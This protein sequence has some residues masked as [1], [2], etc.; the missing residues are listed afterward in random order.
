M[1]DID[2]RTF[3]AECYAP[4]VGEAEVE[5]AGA[6]IRAVLGAA[7]GRSAVVSYSGA[8]LMPEDEVVFHT[9]VAEHAR[10]VDEICKAASIDVTRIVES[11]TVAGFPADERRP[12]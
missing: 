11:V 5:A 8:M 2:S 12:R 1:G 10:D 3:L 4:A 6:R 9:F 7:P